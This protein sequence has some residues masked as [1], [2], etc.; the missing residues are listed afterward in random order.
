MP[1]HD[2]AAAVLGGHLLVFGGG[3]STVEDVVQS[4]DLGSGHA[5]I[6]GHLP[7]P[8]A[9]LQAVSDGHTVYL[10]GG[11]DGRSP[12][13]NVYATTNGRSFR[14]VAALPAG[15]R[16]PAVAMVGGR[17]VVAGGET[18]SGAVDGVWTVNPATGEGSPGGAVAVGP[19]TGRRVR[20][21]RPGL[22][23]RRRGLE[24]DAR[25]RACGASTPSAGKV[26]R[27]GPAAGSARRH[28]G[29]DLGDTALLVG[30]LGRAHPRPGLRGPARDD[31]R[32]ADA[33]GDADGDA[34]CVERRRGG[35]AVRRAADHRRP[36]QQPAA[37]DERAQADRLAVPVPEAAPAAIALLLP[38]RRV[39]GP[40]RPRDPVNEEENDI[41]AEIAYP[42]GR[43]LWSYGHAGVPGRTAG[44]LHQPDDIYPYPPAGAVVADA[45]NCRLLFFGPRAGQAARSAG[46]A[47]ARR[48]SRPASAIRTATRRCPTAT[49]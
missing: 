29:G 41:V 25:R 24:R 32:W 40:P 27:G 39:L 33:A 21:G 6:V 12:Q 46:R 18:G 5:S 14:K 11:Y 8:L 2:A 20:A 13:S 26:A 48:T 30:R 16:Y 4:V 44:Y 47:I 42:S 45:L 23:G 15:V 49:C 43:W 9:D 31:R 37:G 10:V 38:R 28:G 35:A 19:D 7:T 22:R 17:I 34:V 3:A 1:V 36:R